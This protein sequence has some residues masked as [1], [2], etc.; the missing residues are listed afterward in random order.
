MNIVFPV[1]I[2]LS[3]ICGA[4]SGNLQNTVLCGIDGA[5]SA[6]NTALSLI[7]I[8]CFWSGILKIAEGGGASEKCEHLLSPVIHRLFPKTKQKQKITMNVIA[9]LFGTGNAAT[10]AGV[11]AMEGMDKENGESPF[12]GHEMSRFAVM[13]TAS[14]SLF[15]TT[16][17][18]ILASCGAKNP[19]KIVPLVWI[20]SSVS[21]LTALTAEF[22]LCKRRDRK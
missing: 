2:L 17:V 14:I 15:P 18:S 10:P 11:S 1:I 5:K 8:M 4:F 16:V 6:V 20:C 19:L 21:L 3:F 9:N 7:G 22:I 12:P 13:N